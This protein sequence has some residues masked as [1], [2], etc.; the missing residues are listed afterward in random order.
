MINALAIICVAISSN[1]LPSF[2]NMS[3]KASSACLGAINQG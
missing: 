1:A 3:A 2:L